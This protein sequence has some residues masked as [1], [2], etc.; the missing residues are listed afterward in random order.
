MRSM[1]LAGAAL[2]APNTGN[3]PRTGPSIVAPEAITLFVPATVRAT[4]I[5]EVFRLPPEHAYEALILEAAARYGLEP[6]LIRAV[7]RTESAFDPRAISSAGAQGLMQL[8]PAL[9]VELGVVDAF[10]PRDNIM[11]GTRYLSALV[12]DHHGDIALALAS[13]NAGPSVVAHYRGIPPFKETQRYVSTILDLLPRR[14]G[15]PG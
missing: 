15:E 1:L 2:V 8:M 14:E 12:G 4:P 6:A 10:D 5:A 13:Y 3:A 9:A 7:I 11:A